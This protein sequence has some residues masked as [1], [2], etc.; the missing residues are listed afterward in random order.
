VNIHPDKPL[1]GFVLRDISG[2]AGH[3]I[4]LAN[5]RGVRVEAIAVNIFSGPKIAAEDVTGTGLEG[6]AKLIPPPRPTPVAPSV[7]TYR[8]GMESGAPN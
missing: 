3:G 8:L 7:P 1:D 2:T 4:T 5:M 6:A